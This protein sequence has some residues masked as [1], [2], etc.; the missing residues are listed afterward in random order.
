MKR[1]RTHAASSSC[2]LPIASHRGLHLVPKAEQA[3]FRRNHYKKLLGQD[4]QKLEADLRLVRRSDLLRLH[5]L[6]VEPLEPAVAEDVVGAGLQVAVALREVS[7]DELLHQRLGVL[8]EIP[9][10]MA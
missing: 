10:I 1:K 2:S 8:V 6:Q 4:L 3:F 9:G 5:L 7:G